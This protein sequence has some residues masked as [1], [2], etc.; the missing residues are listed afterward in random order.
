MSTCANT[1]AL[2]QYEDRVARDGDAY[3]AAIE[4]NWRDARDEYLWLVNLLH[5]TMERLA[6]AVVSGNLDEL[7]AEAHAERIVEALLHDGDLAHD[8]ERGF[9]IYYPDGSGDWYHEGHVDFEDIADALDI[10][11]NI[12]KHLQA[13]RAKAGAA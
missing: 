3:E 10:P 13:A 12:Y 9:P 8:I 7:S 11:L 5:A 2:M 6:D 1:A 4:D